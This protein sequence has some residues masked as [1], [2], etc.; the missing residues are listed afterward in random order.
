M[1]IKINIQPVRYV[2]AYVIQGRTQYHD[3]IRFN[4]KELFIKKETYI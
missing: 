1:A 2:K 4:F 3:I